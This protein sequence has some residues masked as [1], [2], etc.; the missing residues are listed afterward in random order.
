MLPMDNHAHSQWSWDNPEGSMRQSCERALALGLPAVAFTDHADFTAW[1]YPGQAKETPTTRVI[2]DH[3]TSGE[4]DVETYWE[5]LE[6]CRSSFPDLRILSGIEA[7]E[8]HIFASEIAAVLKSRPFDR[9]LGSLH[10]L[11]YA[12]SLVYA[13]ALFKTQDPHEVMRRYFTELLRLVT[14][15]EVFQVLAHIDYP[16]RAWPKP[17]RPYRATDFEE[18]YRTVLRALAASD[19]ALE[20]NTSGPWPADNVVRWW[21]EE[22]GTAISFGS[23]AHEPW[24]VG[25]DFAA[26]KDLVEGCGFR[27]GRAP[28][29]FWRR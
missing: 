15:S 1:A 18:E 13:P 7:G 2:A 12:G 27:P 23:D 6:E 28:L 24:L 29:D 17:L 3:A 9:V 4:L 20:V 8:P 14:T 26:A 11:E 5:C 25:K 22:G 16:M 21:Y 19:R 10:S